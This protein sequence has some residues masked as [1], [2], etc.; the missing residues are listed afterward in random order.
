MDLDVQVDRSLLIISNVLTASQDVPLERAV[1]LLPRVILGALRRRG[2]DVE[3]AIEQGWTIG[4]LRHTDTE[5]RERLPFFSKPAKNS[6]LEPTIYHMEEV[7][8]LLPSASGE[9]TT[10]VMSSGSWQL[11]LTDIDSPAGRQWVWSEFG[12]EPWGASGTLRSFARGSMAVFMDSDFLLR[13]YTRA[14]DSMTDLP[15]AEL[16]MDAARQLVD[17][18]SSAVLDGT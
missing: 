13:V 8:G 14:P 15:G 12:M 6:S 10:V 16:A 1:S 11:E 5:L 3:S 17:D 4:F 18:V 2:M 9:L 7:I